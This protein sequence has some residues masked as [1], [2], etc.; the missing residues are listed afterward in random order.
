MFSWICPKCG[1]DV[2]PS[3]TECPN[4]AALAATAPVPPPQAA[5]PPA[6]YPPNYPPP[7][8]YPPQQYPPSYGQP[9]YPQTPQGYPPPP[10]QGYPPQQYPPQ[11]AQQYPPQGYAPPPP[12]AAAP[13]PP[14]PPPPM[15]APEM[16][17]PEQR[18]PPKP[19]GFLFGGQEEPVPPAGYP[20]PP[21]G[22]APP[23]M[24][25]RPPYAEPKTPLPQWLVML[26]VAAVVGLIIASAVWWKQRSSTEAAPVAAVAEPGAPAAATNAHPLSK[27]IE[28]SGFRLSEDKSQRASVKMLI[29]N[30]STAD[31]GQL[32]LT[33]TLKAVNA[34]SGDTP[35]ATFDV[36]VPAIEPLGTR[37]V[38]T[39]IKTTLRAYEL[40]DWQFIRAEF[41]IK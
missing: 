17:P 32:D 7:P 29:I 28:I 39:P 22:S 2:P 26:G 11:Y 14:P 5:A 3:Y 30:H 41:Q 12:A 34:K 6:G 9:P 1:K 16:L 36:R 35:L 4:C 33:V 40:P 27:L 24:A 10:P 23:P 15:P 21:T 25:H 18:R 8:G 31:T 19:A 13:P 37:E 38:S 20:A